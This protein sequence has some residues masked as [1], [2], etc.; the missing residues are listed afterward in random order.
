MPA[1]MNATPPP[2]RVRQP[3]NAEIEEQRI[4]SSRKNRLRWLGGVFVVLGI[5]L[6]AYTFKVLDIIFMMYIGA[7]LII[8]LGI[9]ILFL[10]VLH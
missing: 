9:V 2:I 1:P 6:L 5:V 3:N 7:G 4:K 10:S 8:I